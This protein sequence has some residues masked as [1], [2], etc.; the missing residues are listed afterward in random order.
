METGIKIL[1][2]TI[3]NCN[4]RITVLGNGLELCYI[5]LLQ[6]LLAKT[7]LP[8]NCFTIYIIKKPILGCCDTMTDF[9]V[10]TLGCCLKKCCKW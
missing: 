5:H 6:Y 9:T 3:F 8:I 7:L 2:E 4:L 1:A 10:T